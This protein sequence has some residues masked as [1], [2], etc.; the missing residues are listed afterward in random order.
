ML[1]EGNEIKKIKTGKN[2]PNFALIEFRGL[3]VRSVEPRLSHRGGIEPVL[4]VEPVGIVDL[5]G[6]SGT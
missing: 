6:F 4:P 3:P 5:I 2:N 1:P